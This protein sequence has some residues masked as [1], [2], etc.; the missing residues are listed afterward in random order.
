MNARYDRMLWSDLT[1]LRFTQ[2]GT[3]V[4]IL[5]PGGKTYLA[6][7]SLPQNRRYV[8]SA[9]AFD[10]LSMLRR[11]HRAAH[12]TVPMTSVLRFDQLK[13]GI[14]VRRSLGGSAAPPL[15]IQPEAASSAASPRFTMSP[16]LNGM[17]SA[18]SR[19]FGV[20]RSRNSSSML[21][22][23]N[24]SPIESYMMARASTSGSTEIRC[25]HEPIA[26]ASSLSDAHIRAKVRVF[27]DSC[28]GGSAYGRHVC[29][30]SD[31]ICLSW[32]R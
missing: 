30:S 10:R 8:L 17:P 21:N 24:S 15:A 31:S 2:V 25:M 23:L 12:S 27:P 6:T 18:V 11:C 16:V 20:R 5:G 14:A 3:D 32:T 22:C 13:E 7:T 1:G 4:L 28:S 29:R 26:S 19:H 9:H